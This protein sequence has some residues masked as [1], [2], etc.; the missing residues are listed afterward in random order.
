[1]DP[2]ALTLIRRL[3]Q[4]IE[5]LERK[6]DWVRNEVLP[7]VCFKDTQCDACRNNGGVCNC[8]LNS[9]SIT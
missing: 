5:E 2:A 9:P 7:E 1:M 6:Q 3:E 8:I 4:R